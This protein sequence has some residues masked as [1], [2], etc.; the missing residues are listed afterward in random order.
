MGPFLRLVRAMS[1]QVLGE[2]TAALNA[3]LINSRS[4]L[5]EQ[6]LQPAFISK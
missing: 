6:K 3:Y 2:D 1:L 4:L 5:K